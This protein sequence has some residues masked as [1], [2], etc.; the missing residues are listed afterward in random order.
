[1]SWFLIALIG[2]FVLAGVSVSDKFILS[3]KLATPAVFVFY[4]TVPLLVLFLSLFFGV[5]IF[6]GLGLFWAAISGLALLFG[7]WTMYK[8][9]FKSEVSHAGPLLGAVMP[10]F[11]LVI[12]YFFLGEV[13][14]DKQ[15]AACFLLICG[16]FL[17][18]FE[19][20]V[21]YN[22]WHQGFAWI[23]LA[24]FSFSVSHV[25]AKYLYDIY[26]FTAGLVW[27]R[28]MS[29]I[30]GLALI[31]I[32][33]VR[34]EIKSWFKNKEKDLLLQ[35]TNKLPL[36]IFNKTFGL[37]GVFLVQLAVALGSVTLVNAMAG[38]QFGL[39]IILV[40]LLSRFYPKIFK[41]EYSKLEVLQEIIAVVVIGVGL[42]ML[43]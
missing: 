12:S 37:V 20:S 32:P 8:G 40:A 29:G 10:I 39:L 27:S 7:F 43:I 38:A 6:L 17:I 30:F 34:T 26:G 33:S 18:S 31:F 42:G 5:E 4:S 16:S 41:E 24:G 1:M 35:N 28:G 2:Y 14:S 3:K 13:L 22:G 25:A 19:K 23:I 11:V 9:F 36:I 21:Q 15:L